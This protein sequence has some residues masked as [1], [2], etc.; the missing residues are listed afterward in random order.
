[1]VYQ[2]QPAPQPQ[3]PQQQQPLRRNTDGSLQNPQAYLDAALS[4]PASMAQFP[5]N[6]RDAINIGDI[7]AM[8][9]VFRALQR[10]AE[11]D[12]AEAQLIRPGEDPM[13]PVVQVC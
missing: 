1:M 5:P 9:G 8:Q 3:Q 12:R 6:L 4:N 13:D 11:A 2:R 7:E 10:Q